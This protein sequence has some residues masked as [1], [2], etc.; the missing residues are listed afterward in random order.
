VSFI[1]LISFL[2]IRPIRV[3][4]ITNFLVEKVAFKQT[5]TVIVIYVVK[6]IYLSIYIIKYVQI[7]KFNKEWK[8]NST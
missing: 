2:D 1:F 8:Y 7:R 5:I 6:F 3:V 4:E